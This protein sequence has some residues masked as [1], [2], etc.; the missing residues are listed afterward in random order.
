MVTE[1]FTQQMRAEGLTLTKALDEAGL[2]VS[3]ALWFYFEEP[4]QWRYVFVSSAV[5]SIGPLKVYKQ[6]LGVIR[7]LNGTLRTL[8]A[9]NI[10]AVPSRRSLAELLNKPFGIFS[11]SGAVRM[12]PDVEGQFVED[13]YIYRLTDGKA[14]R[15]SD[16]T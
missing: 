7:A 15:R 16:R 1:Q 13:A 9:S 5:G 6:V 11:E 12:P 10:V 3:S 4:N 8:G 14:A 2:R